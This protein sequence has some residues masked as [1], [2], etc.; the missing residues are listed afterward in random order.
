MKDKS[1]YFKLSEDARAVVEERSRARYEADPEAHRKRIYLRLLE[2]G[3]IRCPAERTLLRYGIQP[4]LAL[5][6]TLFGARRK[7]ADV[8]SDAKAA[9]S[10]E[11]A[12]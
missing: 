6:R 3:K 9:G 1:R 11:N 8:E 12:N 5:E 2:T 7:C 4:E 10:M